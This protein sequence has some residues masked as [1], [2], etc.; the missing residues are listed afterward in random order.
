MSTRRPACRAAS[1]GTV[2]VLSTAR[3]AA[4]AGTVPVRIAA[5]NVDA[6]TGSTTV[7]DAA[8]STVLGGIGNSNPDGLVRPLD[9][10]ALEETTSNATTVAPIAADLNTLYKTTAYTVPALQPGESGNSPTTGNGPSSLIYNAATVQL[11]AATT[12]GPANGSSNG[13]YRQVARYEF[14]P[15]AAAGGTAAGA[16]YLYVVHA[17]SG[18][19]SA[20]LI[21]RGQEAALVRADADGLPAN[22]RVLYAGDFNIGASTEQSIVNYEA[23]GGQGQA[24]DPLNMPGNY[25]LNSAF[26]GILTESS[27]DLRYRDDLQLV[28]N[29]VLGDANGLQYAAGSYT[30]FGNNGTTAVYGSVAASSNTALPGLSNR[31]TVLTALTQVTDHLPL[32]ADYADVVGPTVANWGLTTGGTWGTVGDWTTTIVPSG[33]GAAVT[34]G[35]TLAAAGTVTLDGSRTVGRVTFNSAKAYTLAVGTGGTLTLDDTGDLNGVAPSITVAAGSHSITAPVALAAGATV[36]TAAN[37]SLTFG[38]TVTGSGTLTINAGGAVVVAA[39]G[40][41]GVATVV[42]GNLTFTA[43]ANA[44]TLVQPVK[45]LSVAAGA[46]VTVAPGSAGR[47]L[48]VPAILSVVGKVDLTNNDMDVPAGSLAAVTALAAAGFA[49]GTWSG[50]GPGQLRRRRRPRPPD[51]PRRPRQRQRCRGPLPL[52]R[53]PGRSPLADVL[54]KFTTYGDANL[55]GVGQRRRLRPPRRRRSS[56][57]ADR[58]GRTATSTTTAPSTGPTTPWPTTPSTSRRP[59]PRPCSPR[60]RPTSP[61]CPSRP[62]ACWPSRASAGAAGVGVAPPCRRSS[63]GTPEQTSGGRACAG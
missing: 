21:A 15:V 38:N 32:V 3:L 48:L 34:F 33:A 2:A 57:H 36:N 16:F 63:P 47:T 35:P 5:Y 40:S 44:A 53:R 8:I 1:L 39:A 37:T 41:L 61:P 52:V 49:G 10:L 9:I 17:K 18:S 19:T 11:L 23:A 30:A 55:D 6:D 4:A 31:T 14:Q 54:V 25:A 45:G 59:R 42:N 7:N 29:K 62:S 46:V 24:N 28:N 26:A 27:T 20:D 58:L 50:T 13:V 12:V 60:P 51:G 22:S 43:T 56:W